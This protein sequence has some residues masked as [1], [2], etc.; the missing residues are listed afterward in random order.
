MNEAFARAS[1]ERCAPIECDQREGCWIIMGAVS[2][3]ETHA[4]AARCN[5]CEG[6]IQIA[7]W[8]APN[9]K[10]TAGVLR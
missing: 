8:R 9:F 7:K 3:K 5:A 1:R 6:L 4:K 2:A 10:E